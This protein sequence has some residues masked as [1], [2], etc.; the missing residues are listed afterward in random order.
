MTSC[1]KFSAILSPISTSRGSRGRQELMK[2][3]PEVCRGLK[4]ELLAKTLQLT[5][6]EVGLALGLLV[7]YITFQEAVTNLSS[8]IV[9]SIEI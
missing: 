9:Y 3:S 8:Q 7:R 2:T 1:C 5:T 6:G 4:N